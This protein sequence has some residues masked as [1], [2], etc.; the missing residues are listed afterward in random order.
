MLAWFNDIKALTEKSGQEKLTFVKAHAR[1]VSGA[2]KAFSAAS[3]G[4]QDDDADAVPFAAP[5]PTN[6]ATLNI[7]K[8]PEAGGRIPS[9]LSINRSSERAA[10]FKTDDIILPTDGTTSHSPAVMK[11]R[12]VSSTRGQNATSNFQRPAEFPDR[13]RDN[14]STYT[15]AKSRPDVKLLS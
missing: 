4:M 12:D 13:Y 11:S 5:V 6:D 8:R 9:D 3:E 7:P 10:A 1:N 15:G 14:A 2:S